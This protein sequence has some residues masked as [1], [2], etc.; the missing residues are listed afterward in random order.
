[1][2]F[3][4]IGSRD[5]F[6]CVFFNSG[7]D[8]G[9][10]KASDSND[11]SGSDDGDGDDRDLAKAL[12]KRE[13][14]L[15]KKYKVGKFYTKKSQDLRL[16]DVDDLRKAYK[17]LFRAHIC[18]VRRA[19]KGKDAGAD[20]DSGENSDSS[21][22]SDALPEHSKSENSGSDSEDGDDKNTSRILMLGIDGGGKV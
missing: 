22:D 6:V 5:Y 8:A 3:S 14:K 19:S 1:L 11:S 13:K 2:Y 4:L 12:K 17:K 9:G 7:G 10:S 15:V 21:F 20:F 16:G 18:R